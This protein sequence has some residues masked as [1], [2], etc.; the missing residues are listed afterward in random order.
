MKAVE[1]MLPPDKFLRIHRSYIIAVDKIQKIDRND[2]VY[3]G[4]E[5]IHILD[6]YLQAFRQFLETR[7]IERK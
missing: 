6:G 2:C 5:I 3:I 1:E 7:S 4:E